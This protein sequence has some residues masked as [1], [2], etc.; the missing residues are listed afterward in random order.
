VKE[1]WTERER[2]RQMDIYKETDGKPEIE[3]ARLKQMDR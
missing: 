2:E 3:T 1:R